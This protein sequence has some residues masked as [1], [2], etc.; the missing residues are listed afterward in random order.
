MNK[1]TVL[2]VDDTEE[3]IDILVDILKKDYKVRVA[4][5]GVGAIKAVTRERP[6][7]IFTRHPHAGDGWIRGMSAS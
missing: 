5:N 4:T 6:D 2:V 3:N 1:N 7:I